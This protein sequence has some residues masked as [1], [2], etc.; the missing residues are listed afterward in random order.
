MPHGDSCRRPGLRRPDARC[1]QAR[2][3]GRAGE[4][5]AGEHLRRL[6]FRVL[7]RNVRTREGEIDLIAFDGRTLVFAEVKTAARRRAAPGADQA[8]T[9]AGAARARAARAPA[10]PGSGMAVRPG[11]R[12]PRARELRFDAIGVIVDEH[13]RLCGSSTSRAPGEGGAPAARRARCGEAATA[14]AGAA[15]ARAAG[16]RATGRT[17]GAAARR[18]CAGSPR[19]ATGVE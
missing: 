17:S 13:G 11:R 14:P 7:E 2:E 5:L 16:R 8:R 12:R 19:G 10:P 18:P 6:G 3:L 15:T 1:A 9:P 4:E